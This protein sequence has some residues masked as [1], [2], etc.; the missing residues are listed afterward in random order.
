M[1]RRSGRERGLFGRLR[2]AVARVREDVAAIQER[3]PAAGGTLDVLLFYPGMTAVWTHRVA[4]ALWKRD[5]RF[6]ARLLSHSARLLTAVEI[7]P[8]AELGRRVTIDH[9]AGVVVGETADVG[10]DVHFYHGV[11]LGANQPHAGK[12]HPTV[13]SDVVLGAGATLVGAITVG[14][15]ASIGASAVVSKDVPPGATMVGNPARRVDEADETEEADGPLENGECADEAVSEGHADGSG[16][17]DDVG[18]SETDCGDDSEADAE[19]AH[20]R[21]PC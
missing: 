16:E 8:G 13:E 10:D 1:A 4:H 15:G 11:T 20:S 12:R 14:E 17:E 19:T 9:G 6:A 2:D 21:Q 3:D 7:H 5:R 18:A